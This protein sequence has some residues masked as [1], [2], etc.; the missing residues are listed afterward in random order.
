MRRSQKLAL[1]CSTGLALLLVIEACRSPTQMTLDVTYGGNCADLRGVAIIVGTDPTVSES[2]IATNLFTTTTSQCAPAGAGSRVGTLVVTPNDSIG[3]G[4]VVVLGSFDKPVEQCKASEGYFGCIVARRIFSFVAHTALTIEI[5]LD[6]DCK[7][8]PCDAVSTCKKGACTDAHVDC[9]A[10]GCSQPGQL[11]DGGTLFVDA[12]TSPEA[13]IAELDSGGGGPT[14]A[15]DAASPTD[16]EIDGGAD[17]SSC[18][19]NAPVE[20][21]VGSSL[22]CGAG[23]SCCQ[24]P[25]AG[26]TASCKP[27][28]QCPSNYNERRLDCTST[29]NCGAGLVCCLTMFNQMPATCMASCDE[30]FGSQKRLCARDCE[31][32]GAGPR[33]IMDGGKSTATCSLDQPY[34]VKGVKACQ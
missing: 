1:S 15:G 13:A 4:S 11:S 8:V 22:F 30:S 9:G 23:Q 14:D 6:P 16:A 26:T 17:A 25:M 10:G 20:C 18:P 19:A 31:C 12:P 5:P 29:S 21:P 34:S 28:G 24:D 3:Q 32:A 7:N 33:A 27:T 2:R